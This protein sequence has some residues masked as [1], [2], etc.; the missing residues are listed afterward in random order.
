MHEFCEEKCKMEKRIG[1]NNFEFNLKMFSKGKFHQQIH[2]EMNHT[3]QDHF[4]TEC[5]FKCEQ[6]IRK[7]HENSI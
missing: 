3:I 2:I 7:M 5:L 4:Y 1:G 6:S